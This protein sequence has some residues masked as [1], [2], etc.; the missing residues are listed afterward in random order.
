MVAAARKETEASERRNEQLR[1]QFRDNEL[2]L[3]SQQEQL[4]D[5]KAVMHQMSS[6]RDE[7]ETST[8][9][10]TAPS[11]PLAAT[12]DKMGRLFDSAHLIP[13]ANG[14]DDV[15]PDHP[16]HFSHLIRPALRTDL[17]GYEEF[18]ALLKMARPTSSQSRV[19][20]GNYSG[21]NILGLNSSTNSSQPSLAHAPSNG[22]SGS[23]PGAFNSSPS[24]PPSIN[25][26]SP[27]TYSPSLKDCKFYKRVLAEDIEPSL[28]LDAAPGLS[29]LARRTVLSS[30]ASGTLIV[31]PQSSSNKFYGPIFAC[32]LC[33]ENRKGEP[34]ARRHRFRTSESDDA[35]RYPLCEYCLGRVRATCD[36]LGF[37]RMVKEGLWRA[38]TEEEGK[39]AWEESVRLRERMFWARIGGGVVPALGRDGTKSPMTAVGKGPERK[40]EDS[41]IVVK[42]QTTGS[43]PFQTYSDG[44]KRVSIGKKVL[45]RPGEDVA[46]PA[47]QTVKVDMDVEEEEERLAEEAAE[48]LR[49]EA[50]HSTGSTISDPA[51][52]VEAETQQ[53]PEAESPPQARGRQRSLSLTI[54]GAFE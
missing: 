11:T 37:L 47:G 27:S 43:D 1:S 13:G 30:I 5:L 2:L 9:I 52:V 44:P 54:P 28:R 16:L 22:S 41:D 40:S 39:G 8:H 46:V 6:D 33:G 35:Q 15:M 50:R 36:F 20:S 51:T 18:Q 19:S 23:V 24:A 4:Q 31:E 48:Q 38:E 21:L 34:Y 42:G 10:S 32:A 17:D 45:S 49:N 25:T 14:A 3:A 53:T 29:W 7:N 12:H 26:S